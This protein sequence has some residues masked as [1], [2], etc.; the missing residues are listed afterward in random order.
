[1]KMFP[2]T[3]GLYDLEKF[4]EKL[5]SGKIYR[6][7]KST[8]TYLIQSASALSDLALAQRHAL[9]ADS[10]NEQR[11]TRKMANADEGLDAATAHSAWAVILY[12]RATKSK[13]N[14]RKTIDIRNRFGKKQ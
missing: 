11:A 10:L 12:A 9:R 7:I 5:P 6:P 8:I 3:P 2:E 13:S 4:G 14:I 1:M